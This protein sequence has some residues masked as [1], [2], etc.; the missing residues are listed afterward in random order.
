MYSSSS[1]DSKT[2]RQ[3]F[4]PQ[5]LNPDPHPPA[6]GV[7]IGVTVCHSTLETLAQDPVP[8]VSAVRGPG[9]VDL[10]SI[11]TVMVC[12]VIACQ[13]YRGLSEEMLLF[14]IE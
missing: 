6:L 9:D 7:D 12:L 11:S 2:F 1:V 10:G 14:Q 13:H 3:Q 4:W 5:L 8:A